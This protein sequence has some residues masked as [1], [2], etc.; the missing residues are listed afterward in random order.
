[1]QKGQSF[2]MSKQNIYDQPNVFNE[3]LDLRNNQVN[4][5]DLIEKPAILSLLPD[6]KGKSVLDLGCGHGRHCLTYLTLGAKRVVGV[7][8]SE[9]MINVA[10]SNI[11]EPKIEFINLAMENIEKLDMKFDVVCSSLAFSY[12]E[13]FKA[14]LSKIYQL[15]NDNGY[16][17]FSQD[18]PLSTCHSED[19]GPR[20]EKDEK[21]N[22][23]SSRIFDYSIEGARKLRWFNEDFVKYHR[24][25][26]TIINELIDNHFNIEKVLEPILSKEDMA[27]YPQYQDNYHRPDFL[28]VKA[29]RS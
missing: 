24:T 19:K 14:L 20:W 1:M 23:I 16:L 10:K 29:R 13:D 15:L 22:K 27:K 18:H 8:I 28:L 26:Q 17:I 6:L 12:V 2:K 25:F 7:D 11:K 5:N 4:A 3:Y 9:K 21:G